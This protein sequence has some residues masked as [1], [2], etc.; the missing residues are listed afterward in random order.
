MIGHLEKLEGRPVRAFGSVQNIQAQ[1]LAQLAVENEHALAQALHDHGAHARLALGQ[2]K[3]RVRVRDRGSI[4][5]ST[6]PTTFPSMK[7]FMAS[8]HPRG[9]GAVE[10]APSRTPSATRTELQTEFRL[11]Q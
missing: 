10:L 1:K 9:P 5:A 7:E 11:H 4:D 6:L 2:G 3:R 8:V